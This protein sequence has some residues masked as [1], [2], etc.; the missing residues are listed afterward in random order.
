M[1][2]GRDET[3]P[4]ASKPQ[5]GDY[6]L[7]ATGSISQKIKECLHNGGAGEPGTRQLHQSLLKKKQHGYQRHFR[8]LVGGW[9][10]DVY[11]VQ[12]LREDRKPFAIVKSVSIKD[13]VSV[14]AR[15]PTGTLTASLLTS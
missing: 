7:C 2:G 4:L 11:R 10:I 12:C 9:K 15:I 6:S 5:L 3:D 13:M 8:V 1:C 14:E